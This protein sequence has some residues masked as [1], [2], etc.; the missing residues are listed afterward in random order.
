MPGVQCILRQAPELLIK[1]LKQRV[2]SL[3]AEYPATRTN[4]FVAGY[5]LRR[6]LLIQVELTSS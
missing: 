3:T 1:E 4:F 6:N 5:V 2:I